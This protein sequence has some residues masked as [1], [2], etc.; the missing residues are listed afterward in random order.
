MLNFRVASLTRMIAQ[1][2]AAG[3]AVE[4]DPVEHASGG[5]SATD[6]ILH[7]FEGTDGAFVP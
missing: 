1:L 4:I 3:I 2:Q 6:T 7:A 5:G